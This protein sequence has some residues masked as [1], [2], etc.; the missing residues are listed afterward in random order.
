M[1]HIGHISA[2]FYGKVKL[3]L[4]ST[5]CKI[6]IPEHSLSLEK[7]N[8]PL[9]DRPQISLVR[10][11]SH[12]SSIQYFYGTA[13]QWKCKSSHWCYCPR[14][15]C[16]ISF[17][18]QALFP[19]YKDRSLTHESAP[20]KWKHAPRVFVLLYTLASIPFLKKNLLMVLNIT[21]S[22]RNA[23]QLKGVGVNHDPANVSLPV[24]LSL[25]S[26]YKQVLCMLCLQSIKYMLCKKP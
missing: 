10:N 1:G 15:L 8:V 4:V 3:F 20:E 22:M 9:A 25:F 14:P 5:F 2:H 6:K 17:L 19:L 26:R 16:E 24:K 23:L 21:M 7:N 12:T 11:P 13:Q 18:C